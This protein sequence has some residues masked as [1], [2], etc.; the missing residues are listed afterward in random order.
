M[1]RYDKIL[2]HLL[3]VLYTVGVVDFWIFCI[4]NFLQLNLDWQ[5]DSKTKVAKAFFFIFMSSYSKMSF[6]AQKGKS[7]FSCRK[8]KIKKIQKYI[9]ST[10]LQ[11]G[12]ECP[13]NNKNTVYSSAQQLYTGTFE[14]GIY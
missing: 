4:F 5:K 8:L 10:S 6:G 13:D 9:T 7:K 14:R 11:F 12:I 2:Y 1:C 3:S